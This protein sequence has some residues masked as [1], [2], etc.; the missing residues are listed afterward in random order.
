MLIVIIDL[1]GGGLFIKM[2]KRTA[3]FDEKDTVIGPPAAQNMKLDIPKKTK[4]FVDQ[5][6]REREHAPSMQNFKITSIYMNVAVYFV[7]TL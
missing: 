5:T 2:L 6:M 1:T 7:N 3:T 4:L